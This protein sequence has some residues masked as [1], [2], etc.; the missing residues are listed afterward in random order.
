MRSASSVL[1]PPGS[2]GFTWDCCLKEGLGEQVVMERCSF[3][4][5]MDLWSK[6]VLAIFMSQ[7]EQSPSRPP[8]KNPRISRKEGIFSWGS[9]CIS[10]SPQ[11]RFSD[12]S[13]K[14]ISGSTLGFEL[15]WGSIIN[16]L[17]SQLLS[18]T[19]KGEKSQRLHWID[20]PDQVQTVGSHLG[21]YNG[22]SFSHSFAAHLGA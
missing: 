16:G 5:W 8:T 4:R 2:S 12:L 6:Y 20:Y 9:S 21:D 22:K 15:A 10:G 14:T 11:D 7:S 3:S 13:L 17:G 18:S 1:A 19:S